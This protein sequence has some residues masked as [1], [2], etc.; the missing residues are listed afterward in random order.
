MNESRELCQMVTVTLPLKDWASIV[1]AVGQSPLPLEEKSGINACIF[2][3][4]QD[5]KR[6]LAEYPR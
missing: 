5:S 3:A 4:A 6:A 2:Q 1:A